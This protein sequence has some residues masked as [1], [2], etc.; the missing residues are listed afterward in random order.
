MPG[1]IGE[2]AASVTR[3]SI[4]WL[5]GLALLLASV[6]LVGCV[7]TS[8]APTVA[9][10]KT[11]PPIP[12]GTACNAPGCHDTYK[13]QQPYTGPCQECHNTTDW[14]QVTYTH[15]DPTFDQGMH[16]TLGCSF[17]HTEGQ[18]LPTGGCGVCHDAP[19]GGWTQCSAC[20]TTIAF[21][22][23]KSPP[24]GH[25]SLLGGHAKLT[26]LDCHDKP[27]EP[28]VP[29]TCVDCHPV[30]HTIPVRTCQDCHDPALGTFTTP[31]KNFPHKEFFVLSGFHKTLKCAQCHKN[32]S[33]NEF[34]GTPTVCVGCHGP[35]HGGLTDCAACHTTSSFI[36]ST[37]V[38]STVFPLTGVHATLA[39]SK[40]HPNNE[41]VHTIS[42]NGGTACVD[43]HG[44]HH[45]GLTDCA[46][47]HTPRGFQFT[48]FKHSSVFPL[49]GAHATLPCT[50]CHPGGLFAKNISKNTSRNACV[51]CHGVHHGNQTDC[52]LCHDTAAF[53]PLKSG[54]DH[55]GQSVPLGAA[56]AYPQPCG[57]CHGT[58]S[59]P[60][61]SAARTPCSSCHTTGGP[62]GA[63]P[64]PHGY[65]SG[66]DCIDCHWPTTF[67]DLSH[68]THPAI[69]IIAPDTA[70]AH[71]WTDFGPYPNGCLGCHPGL[72]FQTYT[73]GRCHFPPAGQP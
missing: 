49:V 45:G 11:H 18:A 61:F 31:K 2:G 3:R 69:P 16:P 60:D 57:W 32:A 33:K 59:T 14:S 67:D 28:A 73:C 30:V 25:V 58:A 43:C 1:G 65:S 70:P 68:F 20:H 17:C 50:D 12:A 39:C 64:A 26:C 4:I 54:V 5:A 52:T 41:F 21:G 72:Q 9:L 42:T 13:H 27:Q 46:A 63:T 35:H 55:A 8:S 38:H 15:K 29:R 22:L 23:R 44:P 10:R 36:P 47:C 66:Q 53:V 37:F 19:H 6:A 51:D 40:C 56:H 48:T 24:A 62:S 7:T 34:S 71:A